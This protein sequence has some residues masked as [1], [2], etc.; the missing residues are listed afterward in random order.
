MSPEVLTQDLATIWAH[1]SVVT[2]LHRRHTVIPMRFGCMLTDKTAVIH[3]LA[4]R[5]RHYRR[6]LKELQGCVE[7]GI[8]LLS[9]EPS[10]AAETA[11]PRPDLFPPPADSQANSPGAGWAY[12]QGRRSHF[13]EQDRQS[14]DYRRIAGQCRSHF[15]GLFKKTFC[16]AHHQGRLLSLAFLVP[17]SSLAAFGEAFRSFRSEPG[18]EVLLSG[19]WPPYSFVMPGPRTRGEH[20]GEVATGTV[21]RVPLLMPGM[22]G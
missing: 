19:P 14:Q 6:L 21:Q 11:S 8:R 1:G 12:L 20:S 22:W 18:T 7:M 3:L 4:E 15:L 10:L 5:Y 17:K 16:D 9:P 13:H 2:A